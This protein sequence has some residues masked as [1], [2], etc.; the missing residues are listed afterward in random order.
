MV[1]YF[2]GTGNSRYV[3]K[4]IGREIDD[5]VSDLFERIRSHDNSELRSESPWVVVVPTY[6]W[7]IPHIVQEWL[8]H[9]ALLGNGDIYFVMTCGGSIGNAGKYLRQ[10]CEG[11]KLNY[12]GCMAVVMPENYLAMFDVPPRE[13]ALE[14]IRKSENVIEKAANLIKSHR[15][16]PQPDITVMD[17]VNS[18]IV[19]DIFYPAFVHAKKFYATGACI[20]CGKCVKLCPLNNISLETDKPVW[21]KNCTHCMACICNCPCEAIE[22]GKHSRGKNRYHCPENGSDEKEG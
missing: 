13:K 10:L 20:S 6:A 11:K 5:E 14:V 8:E 4:R 1:L 15:G 2:S 18:G 7:R 12:L 19:N 16:F 9:T 22:Y 17:R 3:A 21:G